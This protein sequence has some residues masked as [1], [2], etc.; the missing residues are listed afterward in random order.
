MVER[1]QGQGQR[2][3]A[4]GVDRLL[5]PDGKLMAWRC[6][7]GRQ[8]PMPPAS[9]TVNSVAH[10]FDFARCGSGIVRVPR[11]MAREAIARGE[12]A[13]VLPEVSS[14]LPV[15]LVFLPDP[16]PT[17]RAFVDFVVDHLLHP[18]DPAR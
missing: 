7:D 15:D 5:D 4:L 16:T 18:P 1:A 10:A 6:P 9:I 17:V 13:Q 14:E 3:A 11:S 8:A 12:L 2:L